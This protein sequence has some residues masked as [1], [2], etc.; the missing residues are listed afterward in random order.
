MKIKYLSSLI[1]AAGLSACGSSGNDDETPTVEDVVEEVVVEEGTIVGPFSTG[2]TSEPVSVYYDLDAGAVVDITEEE[3]ANNSVWD[4][5]FKRTAISLNTH[6]DNTVGMYFTDVNSDFFD[7]EG[8]A[9][10]D[11]F[12]NATADTE[13][14]DYL[15]VSSDSMPTDAEYSYDA[16]D[17]VVGDKFY[18][19]DFTTHQVTAADDVYFIVSSDDAYTKFRVTS[20]TTAGFTMSNITLEVQHQSSLDGETEFAAAETIDLDLSGCT[21]DIYVDFDLAEQ[22]SVDDAWDIYLPCITVD[23]D[24]GADFYI[25][26]A[27]DASAFVDTDNE[28]TGLDVA[29]HAYYGFEANSTLIRS[30]DSS[31]WYQYGL[32]GGHLLWSQYG[33]YLIETNSG[34]YK[35]Q[36][37]SYYDDSGTSG[38]YSFRAD[39]TSAE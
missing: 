4:I 39:S 1:I 30:F 11:S 5:A 34:Q 13:L 31:P 10:A 12:I 24:T 3:A 36:I 33:V 25:Y 21:T 20:L 15:A 18:N 19:Y 28:Y 37:T 32:N 14:D 26:I 9:I 16:S 2:S 38:N 7:A 29:A 35:L 23:A 22:V 8:V 17:Y 27:D 6:A